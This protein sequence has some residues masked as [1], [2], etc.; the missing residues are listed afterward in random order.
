MVIDF[1]DYVLGYSCVWVDARALSGF[2]VT[3]TRIREL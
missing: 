2:T 1:G 3:T